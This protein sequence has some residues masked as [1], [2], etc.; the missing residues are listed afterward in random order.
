M[1]SERRTSSSR[2]VLPPRPACTINLHLLEVSLPR[3][4]QTSI[5][6]GMGGCTFDHGR[7]SL[8]I[9]C[10]LDPRQPA[11]PRLW[12]PAG[13]PRASCCKRRAATAAATGVLHA[14][15][16]SASQSSLAQGVCSFVRGL[17][18]RHNCTLLMNSLGS[19]PCANPRDCIPPACRIA[20]ALLSPTCGARERRHQ[21]L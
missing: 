16:G 21:I 18:R 14:S 20:R 10:I 4:L 12:R 11:P 15:S 7:S 1:S 8:H 2:L 5:H 17:R 3:V 19:Y 9:H 13:C 6:V